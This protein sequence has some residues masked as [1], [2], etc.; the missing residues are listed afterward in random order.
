MHT[1]AQDTD[2]LAAKSESRGQHKIGAIRFQQ[3]GRAHVRPKS[4]GNEG[5]HV[6]ESL[7]RFTA[8]MREIGNFL[9]SQN[10]G[11]VGRSHHAAGL[12][13]HFIRAVQTFTAS[14]RAR[15]LARRMSYCSVPV[16]R[17]VQFILFM[18]KIR[19]FNPAACPA[20]SAVPE[21]SRTWE[22]RR[23]PSP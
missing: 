2:S 5:D 23:A 12:V 4:L 14:T 1:H 16:T 11:A 10:A 21:E 3:I 20:S 22:V 9:E 7:G 8:L 13:H 6:H 17:L 19:E 15:T 18:R